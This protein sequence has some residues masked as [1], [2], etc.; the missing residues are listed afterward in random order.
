M[1][2]LN[3]LA[4]QQPEAGIPI[5]AVVIYLALIV[6]I[7]A[8][9]WKVFEKAGEPGWAAIVPIYNVYVLT[10][11]SGLPIL[12]F[13]LCFVP[14]VSIIPAFYIPIKLGEK[15]GKDA[16]YSIL[17]LALFPFVGYPLLGFGDAKY[18][19]TTTPTKS[20]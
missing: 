4:Q 14:C 18:R 5:V 15:F 3:L 11:I 1:T 17:L 10:K 16:G 13:I 2:H 7:V 20:Y 8:G 12:W 9:F 19:G 6:V